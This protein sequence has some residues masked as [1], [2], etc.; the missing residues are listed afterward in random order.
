MDRELGKEIKAGKD[1][2]AFLM[3][4]C[5]KVEERGYMKRFTP[6]ELSRMKENL[7]ETDIRINDIEEEKK[8]VV[9]AFKEQLDPL[10]D[11]RK[12][13]LK[14]LKNK[15]EFVSEDCFK[16][17]DLSEKTVGYY[18]REGDLIESRPA[19]PEELQG[20]LFAMKQAL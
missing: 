4:N 5:E 12:R 7:S 20:N 14:G 18:N 3:A 11:E 6:E 2:E 8:E 19:Y 9:K 17:V 15:A 10:N 1:R 13:I 16:F